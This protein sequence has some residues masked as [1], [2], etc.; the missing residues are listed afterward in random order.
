MCFCGW[1]DTYSR[2]SKKKMS[3]SSHQSSTR[4]W[5]GNLDAPQDSLNQELLMQTNPPLIPNSR[6]HSRTGVDTL[7]LK[8]LDINT[9]CS[10]GHRSLWQVLDSITVSSK[11]PVPFFLPLINTHLGKRLVT[12]NITI[13]QLSAKESWPHSSPDHSCMIYSILR[14]SWVPESVPSTCHPV[15]LFSR[16]SYREGILTCFEHM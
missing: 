8:G 1:I 10:V 16:Q 12:L 7:S 9:L 15:V 3:Y 6:K 14:A 13:S 2:F 11:H 5:S 4:G